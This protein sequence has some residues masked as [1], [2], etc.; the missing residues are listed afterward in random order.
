VNSAGKTTNQAIAGCPDIFV[1]DDEP[2]IASTLAQILGLSGF[3]AEAF[4]DP[5]KALAA[6]QHRCPRL[7]IADV[8]MP[9][10]SG[11]ELAIRTS[12]VCSGCKILFFPGELNILDRLQDEHPLGGDFFVLQKPAFPSELLLMVRKILG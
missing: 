6:A 11:F 2:L 1:V 3:S 8:K 12:K 7:L 9:K 5:L 10:L 4:T